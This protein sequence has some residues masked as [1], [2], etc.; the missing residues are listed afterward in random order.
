[1]ASVRGAPSTN[2]R[3]FIIENTYFVIKQKQ[4]SILKRLLFSIELYKKFFGIDSFIINPRK[5]VLLH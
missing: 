4:H 3:L 1:M 2:D 5:H